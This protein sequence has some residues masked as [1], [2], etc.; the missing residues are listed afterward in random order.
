MSTPQVGGFVVGGLGTPYTTAR[1]GAGAAVNAV[2]PATAGH[3]AVFADDSGFIIEDGGP[4]PGVGSYGVVNAV[5][6]AA[7][8]NTTYGRVTSDALVTGPG[9]TYVLTLSNTLIQATSIVGAEV[10]QGSNTTEGICVTRVSVSVGQVIIV[11]QNLNF[12]DPFN[13]TIVIAFGV[14]R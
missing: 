2:Q 13:G 12:V 1:A 9:G 3:V 4:L 5:A 8:I 6:G 7:S 10:D 14:L 11:I